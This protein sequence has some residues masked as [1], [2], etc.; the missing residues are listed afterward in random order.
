MKKL[1][2][3]V[4]ALIVI[5]IV[6]SVRGSAESETVEFY[7]NSIPANVRQLCLC[8]QSHY[9]YEYANE[10]GKAYEIPN[11]ETI[12]CKVLA[13]KFPN[14][15]KLMIINCELENEES[16]A[17]IKNLAWFSV[18]SPEYSGS[19]DDISYL[20]NMTSLKFLRCESE[21]CEDVSSIGNLTN[22]EELHL[23]LRIDP[24][25][26][27]IYHEKNDI[28]ISGLKNLTKIENLTL[29][30]DTKDISPIGAMKKLKRLDIVN[31][32]LEDGLEILQDMTDLSYLRIYGA[33][34]TDKN[35]LSELKQLKS[36]GLS[37]CSFYPEEAFN[38]IAELTNLE[39][40]EICYYY[41]GCI[42]YY[43]RIDTKQIA[44]LTNLKSLTMKGCY[45]P[46]PYF[47]KN[48]TK[49]EELSL[50][51]N[52]IQY[53]PDVKKLSELKYLNLYFNKIK[54]ISPLKELTKLEELYI[55]SNLG[56][57]ETSPLKD[58][59]N[60][61]RLD[62]SYSDDIE[63]FSFLENADNLEYLNIYCT[64]WSYNKESKKYVETFIKDHPDCEVDS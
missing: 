15:Y 7:G 53:I 41:G 43:E 36:L 25:A 22:L 61:K 6:L 64:S 44:K 14:L 13:E 34:I 28:D 17:Y 37:N 39:E 18:T 8:R 30:C 33:Q 45:L 35:Q 26:Y 47:V 29:Y 23:I 3:I 11:E 57:F 59:K 55:S 5:P 31:E 32:S 60:L 40:L 38:G 16:L 1:L 27:E 48:L 42:P 12:D 62:L 56:R 54:D 2:S 21:S 20:G 49:L 58:I 4:L 52:N 46:K 51:D 19:I 50:C 63:D 24:Y 9:V 10:C